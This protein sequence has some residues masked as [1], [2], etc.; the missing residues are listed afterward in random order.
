MSSSARSGDGYD[1][2][3]DAVRDLFENP[4]AGECFVD[5]HPAFS[6]VS[7]STIVGLSK[8]RAGDIL[9]ELERA[10]ELV[11]TKLGR[12]FVYWRATSSGPASEATPHADDDAGPANPPAVEPEAEGST[13]AVPDLGTMV[14]PD[15]IAF[16]SGSPP[17][18]VT[19]A[20]L[21]NEVAAAL[22]VL[23]DNRG[24]AYCGAW[25]DPVRNVIEMTAALHLEQEGVVR[26]T[27]RRSYTVAELV[28]LDQIA[29]S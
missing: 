23:R 11:R 10:G 25:T 29:S 14:G 1:S 28:D 20:A 24:K 22:E 5:D 16:G 3:R 19:G 9:V 17:S 18:P 21:G 12:A 6:V 2:Q 27:T 7:V 4:G 15:G 13:A 8:T 26:L